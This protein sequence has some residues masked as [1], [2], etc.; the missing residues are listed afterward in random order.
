MDLDMAD[1]GVLRSF[2]I[3]LYGSQVN[4][5]PMNEKMFHT[6]YQLLDVSSKCSDLMDLVPR[7]Y[8]PGKSA[9]KYLTKQA[10]SVLLRQL[11][12]REQHYLSCVRTA[13]FSLKYRFMEVASGL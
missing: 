4:K 6:T 11:K 8:A 12:A 9:M 1:Q 13:A 2:L 10:R 3:K 7:P 5:W